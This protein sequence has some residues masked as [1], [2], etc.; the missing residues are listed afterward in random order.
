MARPKKNTVDYF[1]HLVDHGKTIFVLESKHK[2]DGYAFWFKLLEE[3]GRHENHYFDLRDEAELEYFA[4]RTWSSTGQTVERLELLARIGAIDADLWGKRVVWSDHFVENI[5]DAY[6]KRKSDIPV[7]PALNDAGRIVAEQSPAGNA[8]TKANETK[9]NQTKPEAAAGD[10]FKRFSTLMKTQFEALYRN[11]LGKEYP[12]QASDDEALSLA[13]HDLQ[14]KPDRVMWVAECLGELFARPGTKTPRS[15][16]YCARKM[17]EDY[18]DER[19]KRNLKQALKI[20]RSLVRKLEEFIHNPKIIER[21]FLAYAPETL[22]QTYDR[23]TGGRHAYSYAVFREK[24]FELLRK[25]PNP[26]TPTSNE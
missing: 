14:D 21:L 13:W 15:L 1:P 23:L 6:R 25:T 16:L 18:D 8:Q 24:F 17:V 7:K 19:R 3:L 9:S 4:S 22:Q 2:N 12:G 11:V 5:S 20:H 26:L 10:D